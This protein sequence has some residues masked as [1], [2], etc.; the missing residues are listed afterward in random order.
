MNVTRDDGLGIQ[1]RSYRS[2]LPMLQERHSNDWALIVDV[3]EFLYAKPP[4]TVASYLS[5]VSDDI[6]QV[7]IRWYVVIF[8]FDD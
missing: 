3:D 1:R 5:T 4:E 6:G 2:L 8:F 7:H